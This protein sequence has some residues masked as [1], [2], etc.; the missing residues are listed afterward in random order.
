[1]AII[2]VNTRMCVVDAPL[3]LAQSVCGGQACSRRYRCLVPW[4][5][6][7]NYDVETAQLKDN[8]VFWIDFASIFQYFRNVFMNWNPALF[9]YR[10]SSDT[11]TRA[12]YIGGDTGHS[13]CKLIVD[14]KRAPYSSVLVPIA[15]LVCVERWPCVAIGIWSLAFL[16]CPVGTASDAV[17]R[18]N[19]WIA[20]V[21]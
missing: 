18:R 12:R 7:V 4:D 8:G 21:L 14:A 1:M 19:L 10:C 6:A 2:G 3:C 17:G 5:R 13:I 16:F 11:I 9:S 15:R 20:H